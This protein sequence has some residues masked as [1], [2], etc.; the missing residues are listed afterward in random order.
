MPQGTLFF[1]YKV[2]AIQNGGWFASATDADQTYNIGLYNIH[3]YNIHGESND[4]QDD[5]QGGEWANQ[6][7]KIKFDSD[8]NHC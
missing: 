1:G 7:Y 6:V 3:V 5:G 8:S 4:S 2:F